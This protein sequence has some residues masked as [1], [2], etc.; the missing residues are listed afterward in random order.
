MARRGTCEICGASGEVHRHHI[1]SRAK[2]ARLKP[3]E[4]GYDLDLLKGAENQI[5]L[6]VPCHELTDSHIYWRMHE[7]LAELKGTPQQKRERW[8]AAGTAYQC[9][10]ITRAGKRCQVSVSKKG[11]RCAAHRSNKQGWFRKKHIQ[12]IG[13][14]KNGSKCRHKKSGGYPNGYCPSHQDQIK[15]KR[16]S[17]KERRNM[18]EW[19]LATLE[20][21]ELIESLDL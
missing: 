12:C 16:P 6:C 20:L 18:E 21:D 10:G 2:I 17:A 13:T 5:T 19:E 3:G 14:N 1:I 15:S 11:R 8:W 4:H 7:L 9:E